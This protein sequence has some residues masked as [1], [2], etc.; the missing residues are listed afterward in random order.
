M[1]LIIKRQTKHSRER[2]WFPTLLVQRRF[3]AVSRRYRLRSLTMIHERLLTFSFPNSNSGFSWSQ[4]TPF[5]KKHSAFTLFI[6]TRTHICWTFSSFH[7]RT[8]FLFAFG[9]SIFLFVMDYVIRTGHVLQGQCFHGL[10]YDFSDNLSCLG[11]LA[12]LYTCILG[13]RLL[14]LSNFAICMDL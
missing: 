3:F 2:I 6:F 8:S 10:L 11:K 5:L 1:E 9:H 4:G 14:F 12:D 7:T 13:S